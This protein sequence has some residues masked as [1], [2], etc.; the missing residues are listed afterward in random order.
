M[1]VDVTCPGKRPEKPLSS[2]CVSTCVDPHLFGKFLGRA[3][4][5]RTVRNAKLDTRSARARLSAKKSGYW[6][7]ISRGFALGYRKGPKGSVWLARLIDSK[8]R[9]EVTLGAA[10]DVLDADGER[11]LDYAQAQARSRD[12]L[13]S[14]NSALLKYRSDQAGSSATA[15]TMT[16]NPS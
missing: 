2:P 15:I 6:V 10:D 1:L 13:A 14:L 7:P 5:A 16:A 12:W 8:G 4:L 11:I 9:R 3:N